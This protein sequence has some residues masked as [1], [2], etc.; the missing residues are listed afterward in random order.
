MTTRGCTGSTARS[1]AWF[2]SASA[3]ADPGELIEV[4]DGREDE[5]QFAGAVR[6]E[7]A[8]RLVSTSID[9]LSAVDVRSGV[10][11][12]GGQ[13]EPGVEADLDLGRRDPARERDEPARILGE[14]PGLLRELPQ[15]RRLERRLSLA[16][17]FG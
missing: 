9:D 7:R 2:R 15:G 4:L 6:V 10:R 8:A 11:R 14:N 5:E 17:S 1:R 13:V 3:D 16:L 12:R